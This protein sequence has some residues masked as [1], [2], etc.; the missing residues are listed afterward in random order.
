M[1]DILDRANGCCEACGGPWG[2]EGMAFHHRLALKHG[3]PNTVANLM[4][5]HGGFRINCH[6][7]HQGSIHQNPDRSRRLFHILPAGTDP[8]T[9]PRPIAVR[10]LRELRA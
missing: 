2:G 7:L 9:A 1:T 8:E 5:V 6:N 4:W 3:G 10:E